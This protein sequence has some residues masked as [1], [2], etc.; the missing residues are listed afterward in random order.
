MQILAAQNGRRPALARK[1]ANAGRRR[2]AQWVRMPLLLRS[3]SWPCRWWATVLLLSCATLS[4]VSNAHLTLFLLIQYTRNWQYSLSPHCIELMI[5]NC[6]QCSAEG[7]SLTAANTLANT[8][9]SGSSRSAQLG[10]D[11]SYRRKPASIL[12]GD[13]D[14]D[15]DSDYDRIKTNNTETCCSSDSASGTTDGSASSSSSTSSSGTG[16][17]RPRAEKP[18]SSSDTLSVKSEEGE[19][20]Q[21]DGLKKKKPKPSARKAANLSGDQYAVI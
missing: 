13:S 21:D 18:S 14:S 16:A 1:A 19:A 6:I 8:G 15:S 7:A 10:D 4:T 9:S 11:R 2:K 12:T 5:N 20:E 17:G 3:M